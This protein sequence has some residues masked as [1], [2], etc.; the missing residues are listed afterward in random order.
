MIDHNFTQARPAELYFNERSQQ[1]GEGYTTMDY[2]P[3]RR[4]LSIPEHID[5]WSICPTFK[6]RTITRKRYTNAGRS[7]ASPPRLP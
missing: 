3:Y 5:F 1:K 6:E 4:A 7:C 2:N